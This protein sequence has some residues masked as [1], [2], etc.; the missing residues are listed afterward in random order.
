MP[1]HP[2]YLLLLLAGVALAFLMPFDDPVAPTR[3]RKRGRAAAS[4]AAAVGGVWSNQRFLD[5]HLANAL[6]ILPKASGE[7]F[8]DEPTVQISQAAEVA[9]ILRAD[10][11]SS[12]R[13]MGAKTE[14]EVQAMAFAFAQRLPA[15]YDPVTNVIHILPA[16]AVAAAKV[17]EEEGLL[18]E[19]VLR[20]LLVR[21]AA[22]AQ[23]RQLFPQWKKALEGAEGLD[24][25][26]TIGAV[27]QG[28]AQYVT[29]RVATKARDAAWQ[30]R[31]EFLQ[32]VALLTTPGPK[33]PGSA[34]ID[35]D[36]KFA[37]LK[38]HAFMKVVAKK[39]GRTGMQQALREPPVQ[40]NAIFDPH[41]WLGVPGPRISKN[42]PSGKKGSVPER[43]LAEFATLTSGAG[44]ALASTSI[45]QAD[46]E[47]LFGGIEAKHT[48]AFQ[49]ATA[50]TVT[51]Q[52]KAGGTTITL[53]EMNAADNAEALVAAAMG[54]QG[55]VPAAK[56]EEGAGR[57]SGLV[58]YVSHAPREGDTDEQTRTTQWTYEGRYI[59]GLSTT[60][61]AVTREM[62]DDALEA[63]AE[64]LA[65]AQRTRDSRRR[66]GR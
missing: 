5:E 55:D 60:D 28:H 30:L 39:K 19:G 23:D 45:E 25:M 33:S 20:L 37:I 43:V 53:L 66:R 38:G 6:R 24:A 34:G 59:L 31:P 29:E 54:K 13:R 47:A 3:T 40:R 8:D 52:D 56:L 1:M 57:D 21:M 4:S 49:A 12:F 32:L 63:A 50:W 62:Q 48:A 7:P 22:I 14:S 17:A 27:L 9:P 44:Q 46:V 15:V 16:N 18:S 41:K 65:K 26:S 11:V 2:K 10:F 42:Q 36:I 61:P 35:A 51:R 58:G 64:V